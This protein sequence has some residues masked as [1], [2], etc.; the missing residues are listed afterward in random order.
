MDVFENKPLGRLSTFEET[1]SVEQY[2]KRK[3]KMLHKEF[4]L[5]LTFEDI[6]HFNSLKTKYAVDQYAHKLIMERL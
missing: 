4:C 1:M 3:V 5:H 6:E 2:A